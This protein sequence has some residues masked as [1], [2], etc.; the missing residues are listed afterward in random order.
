MKIYIPSAG[1]SSPEHIG[2]GPIADMPPLIRKDVTFVV[3]QD[4]MNDY[5]ETL[6]QTGLLADGVSVLP[7]KFTGIA[8]VREFIGQG[9]LD[10]RENGLYDDDKFIMLDDD[11]RFIR[12]RNDTDTKL[13][14]VSMHDTIA[15][16]TMVDQL[17]DSYPH[18]GISARQG[19]NNLGV[20][21][22]GDLLSENT[23]TMRAL[24]YRAKDFMKV[25]HCRVPVMEDFDT[26]L[27]LLR[28]GLPNVNIGFYSQD[29][30]MTNAVG[31]CS[32]WRTLQV[33][34]DAVLKLKELHPDFVA[35]RQK[36]N[37]TDASG[38]GTRKE[39]T[40]QW[41]KAYGRG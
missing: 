39:V 37:K 34:E 24:A 41:K 13:R 36:N 31:G 16:F 19:N 23:R 6:E 40:I 2:R 22:A 26:N 9:V 10:N 33:H 12:R 18:V 3:P 7:H 20:G 4:Q 38:F 21:G 17:L 32:D 11:I 30:K 14:P 35:I 27:Q 25:K 8:P 15:M 1:R 28:M 5:W 29:Q